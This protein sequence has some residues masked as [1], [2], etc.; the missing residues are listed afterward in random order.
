MM[1]IILCLQWN[2]PF[3]RLH[4][5]RHWDTNT[6]R[7]CLGETGYLGCTGIQLGALKSAGPG[8]MPRDSDL[9]GWGYSLGI[10]I[11]KSSM[12]FFCAGQVLQPAISCWRTGYDRAQSVSE[13]GA[14]EWPRE[15]VR[16]ADSH[17]QPQPRFGSRVEECAYSPG[18]SCGVLRPH[19]E[20]HFQS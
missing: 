6:M 18:E 16:R 10:G 12:W 8:A 7:P 3:I 4:V 19:F 5:R 14:S 9:I 13:F 15:L 20:K 2:I 17:L 11:F 1:K